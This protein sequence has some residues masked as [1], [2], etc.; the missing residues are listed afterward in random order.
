VT[1]YKTTHQTWRQGDYDTFTD[2][3]I[4]VD[5]K[6]APFHCINRVTNVQA[7]AGKP[8]HVAVKNED[9]KRSVVASLFIDGQ[10]VSNRIVKPKNSAEFLG[11]PSGVAEDGQT[12]FKDFIFAQAPERPDEK[13]YLET[14][15]TIDP[16]VG[17][18]RV[19]FYE[20]TTTGDSQK[21][22]D[23]SVSPDINRAGLKKLNLNI[24]SGENTSTRHINV[25]EGI[26]GA[27]IVSHKIQYNAIYEAPLK[28]TTVAP[29]DFDM[30]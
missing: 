28:A 26:Q 24:G 3:E 21:G 20:W 13:N 8:F 6:V 19:D 30:M 11:F 9:S 4:K 23:K 5:G 15:V 1:I 27:K 29:D 18:I 7:K 14:K 10:P 2:I 12:L 17:F 22:H 16:E 25:V